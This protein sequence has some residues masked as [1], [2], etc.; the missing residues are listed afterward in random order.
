MI[1]APMAEI[2]QPVAVV[3]LSWNGKDDT[4]LCL[5][6][7]A[8]VD[9]APLEVIVVDNGSSDGSPEAVEA[10]FP[11]AVVI[12]M[13][14]NA[15]FSGG[16]NAGIEAAIER[17]A[18]AVLLLN[19]DMVV[20]PGFLGPL[21]DTLEPGVAAACS[22]ILFA[23]SPDRVWYAGA[24]FRPRR[25][26]HGRNIG[27]GEAPLPASAPP[28]PVDC[29]CGGAMLMS[30]E[31][32]DEIGLFDEDL[33]AYR[34]DLDWSLR[35]ARAGRRVVV[36]PASIVRH[37]ISASTGGE[38]SPTSLYYDVRNGLVVSER[39]AP[40]GRVGTTLRRAE[41]VLAHLAQ[42]AMSHRRVEA[43]RA[44]LAGWRDV[45][46]RRLGRRGGGS[47]R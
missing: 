28:Y 42:G 10:E 39:Y 29:A 7:L 43:T 26:H 21:V 19:N 40:L 31:A 5:S 36:V 18:A 34:E 24:T 44:V 37:R 4:L 11:E 8:G 41:S 17:G 3:V 47:R 23:E 14:R 45:R 30:R 2:A 25:G 33:F 6:S 13:G 1:M 22:Q 46:R 9:Y 15:G 27:F 35:A 16:V 20:E 32:I 38:S 12:R